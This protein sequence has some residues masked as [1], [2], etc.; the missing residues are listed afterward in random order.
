MRANLMLPTILFS[1]IAL[2]TCGLN[3]DGIGHGIGSR[4]EDETFD[5]ELGLVK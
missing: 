2:V 4:R 1:L 3:E 5:E